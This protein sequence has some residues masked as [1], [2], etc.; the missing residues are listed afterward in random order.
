MRRH[1]NTT[2]HVAMYVYSQGKCNECGAALMPGWHAD[3]VYAWSRG[4][5]TDL[6]NAQA[7]CPTCS[8]RKG[9]EVMARANS[10]PGGIILRLWQK[11]ALRHL[12]ACDE[13]KRDYL[14]V[15]TPGSGK[16]LM[17]LMLARRM[18]SEGDVDRVVVVTPHN[19][20]RF[21]WAD[22]AHRVGI[23]L[24]PRWS[25]EQGRESADFNGVVVTYAQVASFP[26]L[27]ALQC[28]RPTLLIG[29]EIHHAGTDLKWGE[30]MRVGF[31]HA[32]FRL[33]VSG[34]PF[35]HDNNPIPFVIYE[36]GRSKADFEY[37]YGAALSDG[38]CR[39]VFFPSYE[40]DISWLSRDGIREEH[41]LL[42]PLAR[43]KAA[44]RLRA[45]ISTEGNWL[46]SVIVEADR[47]LSGIRSNSHTD[48]GGLIIAIDQDHARE[49]AKLMHRTIH[50]E[51][52]LAISD[53]PEASA[54]IKA[55]ASGDSKWIVAVRMISEGV[56]IPRLRVAVYATNVTSE[57][58][59]RQAVG[60]LL[61]VIDGIEEQSAYLYIPAV[62]PLLHHARTIKEERDHQLAKEAEKV[63]L[64]N[65]QDGQ[66]AGDESQGI[67]MPL[68][69]DS[70]LHEVIYDGGSLNPAELAHAEHIGRQVGLRW[71][72]EQVAL[73]LRLGAAE[74]GVFVTYRSES[75][76]T[77]NKTQEDISSGDQ[78]NSAFNHT[79]SAVSSTRQSQSPAVQS[80]PPKHER[81]RQLR[82]EVNKIANSL[83]GML[84]VRIRLI[85]QQWKAEGGMP[86]GNATEEDLIRKREWLLKRIKEWKDARQTA[87]S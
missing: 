82:W 65:P 45:A 30:A 39:A 54:K 56:D 50:C 11:Q 37:S 9:D 63:L 18:L 25:N 46:P 28:Q 77:A 42:E 48:A 31:K 59:F 12:G 85:H 57:L 70:R 8:V 15:A 1:F 40:G 55:F 64:P 51:P 32:A 34:T 79:H 3:H 19:H 78:S 26:A 2:E 52:A 21:Q 86:Q 29:D 76:I 33:L 38:V 24:D 68:A 53:D 47:K 43:E 62:E 20:L 60:R 83:A 4:G 17:S 67:F 35:R 80:E 73:V 71:P 69:S 36:D 84:G 10:S 61:R 16:T 6:S 66:S 7:L 22:A 5:Y 58:F 23:D 74:S 13:S 41:S 14:V 75:S 44:E 49:I 72:A 81:K 87:A 27:F